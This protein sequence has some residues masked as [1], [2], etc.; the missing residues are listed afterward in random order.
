[1]EHKLY[2]L[3]FP[4]Y[5]NLVITILDPRRL[6]E[7]CR[8]LIKSSIARDIS[9]PAITLIFQQFTPS[10]CTPKLS[11]LLQ[12]THHSFIYFQWSPFFDVPSFT[13]ALN[14]KRMPKNHF[15]AFWRHTGSTRW[16]AI[17]RNRHDLTSRN[18]YTFLWMLM[19]SLEDK[20]IESSIVVT[21][22]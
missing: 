1:M 20:L 6:Y 17:L 4:L 18:S 21:E 7:F 9:T 14:A 8:Y 5:Q 15:L 11:T 12:P 3:N 16:I 2:N 13:I 22:A 10:R 19:L